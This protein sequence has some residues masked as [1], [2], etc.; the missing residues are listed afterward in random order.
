MAEHHPYHLPGL[1]PGN[2]VAP[3]ILLEHIAL[4]EV[5]VHIQF[6]ALH[7]EDILVNR[8]ELLLQSARTRSQEGNL[9]VPPA[10]VGEIR[11]MTDMRC[12][13]RDSQCLLVRA[14]NHQVEPLRVLPAQGR[15]ERHP[16]LHLP[17]Q[18]LRVILIVA[19]QLHL[20]EGTLLRNLMLGIVE[21]IHGSSRFHQQ[22]ARNFP[23][24]TPAHLVQDSETVQRERV[25]IRLIVLTYDIDTVGLLRMC[26][27]Q[28]LHVVQTTRIEDYPVREF[29]ILGICLKLVAQLL[30]ILRGHHQHIVLIVLKAQFPQHLRE[31]PATSQNQ[32]MVVHPVVP[33]PLAHRLRYIVEDVLHHAH[34]QGREQEHSQQGQHEPEHIVHPS[35]TESSRREEDSHHILPHQCPVA[36]HKL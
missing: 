13:S 34:Q 21:D 8:L 29:P 28:H 14:H 3:H 9:R 24:R 26:M 5:P 31:M 1:Q 7:A 30:H 15:D 12:R 23:F 32:H 25:V 35:P 19:H 2:Q 10:P 33:T 6:Q 20:Q 22:E 36:E 18:T 4:T 16:V 27:N 11:E 17:E